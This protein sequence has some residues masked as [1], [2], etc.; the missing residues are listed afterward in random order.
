MAKKSWPHPVLDSESEDYPNCAFQASVEIKQTRTAF[1]GN[2]RM[3]IGSTTL[4]DALAKGDAFYALQIHCPRT[5]F[6]DLIRSTE[7][8]L[9]FHLPE[10]ALRED[11]FVQ[12]FLISDRKWELASPEFASTFRGMTFQIERG[13]VLAVGSQMKFHAEKRLD[14]LKSVKAI[15][16]IIPHSDPEKKAAEFDFESDR[17]GIVLPVEDF[18]QY[19]LFGKRAPYSQ[20]FVC[21]LVLPALQQ[22][23]LLLKEGDGEAS[24]GARWRRVLRRCL[25]DCKE[26]DFEKDRAFEVAQKLLE[27]PLSRA[28]KAVHVQ[29]SQE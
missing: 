7:S 14:D 5:S 29:E 11:F 21:A 23:L 18:K 1:L 26:A 9:E 24:S 25:G 3:D 4:S 15:F 13:Y 2:A 12:P 16:H 28:F 8:Q 20:M 10:S 22:A 19:G 27:M 17:V 6:R